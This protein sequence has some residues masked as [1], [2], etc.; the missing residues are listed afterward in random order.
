MSDPAPILE[1]IDAFRRS[2]TMFTAV[3]LGIFDGERPQGAAIDRL[4]D[5]CVGLG[6]LMK[7]G[8]AYVN[9]PLADEYLT[10]RSPRTLSG[11]I[12]Y[13]NEA[14]YRLWEHLDDAVMEG[15]NRWRQTFGTEGGVFTHL[16]RTP[17][18]QRDFLMG[19]HGFGMISS[20][21][22]I[23]AF[24]LSRFA[25]FVDL[26]GATGHLALAAREKYTV[27]KATLF[28]LP[29]VIGVAREFAGDRVALVAGDFFIDPLP[30]GD[31]YAVGRILHDWS[32]EKIVALLEKIYAALPDG[33]GLLIAEKLMKEDRSGSVTTHMQSLNMLICTEGRERTLG[34][35]SVLLQGAGFREIKG[36]VTGAPLDAVLAIK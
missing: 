27:M 32:E 10:R 17:E 20:P 33:G 6:L 29:S 16:F 25:S 31:L 7:S 1:L 3:S 35:Y 28:D 2:K 36:S 23:A 11:Y 26:G 13:S 9:T 18:A 21:A 4:L 15:T 19:M 24:D 5:A 30:K 12:R 14:L 34:E 22:V 8:D